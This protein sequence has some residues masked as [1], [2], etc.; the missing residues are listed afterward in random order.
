[1]KHIRD[2]NRKKNEKKLANARYCIETE[3]RYEESI[4]LL[5]EIIKD[6]PEN[7]EAYWLR[8][9]ASFRS[10]YNINNLIDSPNRIK[11]E[12]DYMLSIKHAPESK[13]KEYINHIKNALI[14]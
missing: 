9:E 13:K 4:I 11:V 8:L 2:M 7:Y 10:K 3:G 6:D 14:I 1:M 5:N 12:S